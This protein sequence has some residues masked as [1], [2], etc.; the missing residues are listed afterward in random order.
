MRIDKFISNLWFGSRKE[1][2]RYIKD[3]IIK[4][5]DE[6]IFDKDYEIKFW[7]IVNIGEEKV[8]YKEF[9]YVVL[10][11][12]SWYVSSK[13]EEGWHYSYLD[14]I[15]NC[16]Y[17]MVIDIVWRLD[18]DTTGL[19]FLTN[20]WDLTHKI[21]HPKKDI[22]KKYYVKSE[23]PLSDKDINKL[24]K[25]VKIDDFITK[26]S[27]VEIISENE[28]YLSISEWKFHQIKKMLEAVWNKV[29]ELKRVSIATLE[30]WNLKIWEWR[31]LTDDEVDN[32][33]DIL[34]K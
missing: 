13:R 21:I 27:I 1:V 17:Y 8:E 26:P 24:E 6:I 32:L 9:V 18:F 34:N 16:P 2:S 5:N 33:K 29:V 12:P 4:V 3:W 10:N 11:K 15:Y 22:F 30:L 20:D 19:V 31:Y 25:G 28:I 23:N 14:L 7:D